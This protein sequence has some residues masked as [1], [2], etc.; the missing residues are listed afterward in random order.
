MTA[1]NF[2]PS[3]SWGQQACRFISPF[4]RDKQEHS[5][6]QA[7]LLALQGL[8]SVFD[9]HMTAQHLNDEQHALFKAATVLIGRIQSQWFVFESVSRLIHQINPFVEAYKMSTLQQL[10]LR[11]LIENNQARNIILSNYLHHK[12]T[13][14]HRTQGVAIAY[15]GRNFIMPVCC[16]GASENGIIASHRRIIKEITF[17][18]LE[19]HFGERYDPRS[20]RIRDSEFLANG[21]EIHPAKSWHMLRPLYALSQREGEYV[22]IDTITGREEKIGEVGHDYIQLVN[23]LPWGWNPKGGSLFGHSWIRMVIDGQLYHIGENLAGSILNPDF[24][25]TMP[26]QGKRIQAYDWIH[27]DPTR[28]ERGYNQSERILLKL[29]ALQAKLY[30]RPVQNEAESYLGSAYRLYQRVR[31]E[32]GGTCT[33]AALA[34]LGEVTRH[35]DT[36]TG[37]SLLSKILFNSFVTSILDFFWSI[38]P[39]FIRTKIIQPIQ[40]LTRG[41]KPRWL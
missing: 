21:L 29:E 7:A 30:N 26:R 12:I 23:V 27:L 8:T 14:Q 4:Y 5:V 33:S 32:R 39:M 18:Q 17:D 3:Y 22:H 15:R 40:V 2:N 20:G 9:D 37:R 25:A 19:E 11:P 16:E 41:A 31:T 1:I 24:M 13:Q 38:L 6:A 34:M 10:P 28:D 36:Q 35:E